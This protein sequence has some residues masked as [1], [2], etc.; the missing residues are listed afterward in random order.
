MTV[1]VAALELYLTEDENS[2]KF[3]VNI[4]QSKLC[5]NAGAYEERDL[6]YAIEDCCCRCMKAQPE[7][8]YGDAPCPFPILGR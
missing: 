7:R 8:N 3:S 1:I 4:T 5:M 2:N 6:S